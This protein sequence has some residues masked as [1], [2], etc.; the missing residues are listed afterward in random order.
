MRWFKGYNASTSVF[1]GNS[2]TQHLLDKS[3]L[4]SV[5][6]LIELFHSVVSGHALSTWQRSNVMEILYQYIIA[7]NQKTTGPV[8]ANHKYII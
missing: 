1:V 8:G 2:G 4:Q 6:L 7:C 3:L 5:N